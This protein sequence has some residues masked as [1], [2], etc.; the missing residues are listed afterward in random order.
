MKSKYLHHCCL[1][2]RELGV[3]SKNI[4]VHAAGSVSSIQKADYEV[5]IIDGIGGEKE[6]LVEACDNEY[7]DINR[8]NITDDLHFIA[9][10]VRNVSARMSA[11]PTN[12]QFLSQIEMPKIK[13]IPGDSG[14]CI[15]VRNPADKKFWCIG[16]AI[17]SAPS[18]GCIITPLKAIL[19]QFNYNLKC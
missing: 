4:E 13:C 19:K 8:D 18:G 12:V 9:Q 16:M 14:M 15:Y 6:T 1:D 11:N 17:A 7:R 5:K 10:A 3:H 2:W